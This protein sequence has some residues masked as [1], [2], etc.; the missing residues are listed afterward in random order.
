MAG[1]S[2]I[3]E[4]E[5]M[6]EAVIA[7]IKAVQQ[8][9][10]FATHDYVMGPVGITAHR[11]WDWAV[12]KLSTLQGLM[13]DLGATGSY[14]AVAY[15]PLCCPAEK[16]PASPSSPP[17]FRG[18][19]I[20]LGA[21]NVLLGAALVASYLR[22]RSLMARMKQKD[23]E[24]STLLSKIFSMQESMQGGSAARVYPVLSPMKHQAYM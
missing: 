18:L 12:R 14:R 10:T 9:L 19:L 16:R 8:R 17:K 2:L 20:F 1:A 3:T 22:N 4:E 15:H 6:P 5:A 21:S 13:V 7:E 24:L 11:I 23:N